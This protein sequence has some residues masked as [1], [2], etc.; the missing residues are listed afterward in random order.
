MQREAW[1]LRRPGLP[2]ATYGQ[3]FSHQVWLG[4][5]LLLALV[6]AQP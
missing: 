4:S 1:L 6:I 5:L 3:H 2:R